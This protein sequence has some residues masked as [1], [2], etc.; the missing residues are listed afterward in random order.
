[1]GRHTDS[2]RT[3][4]NEQ[5]DLNVAI[6]GSLCEIG[7]CHEDHFIVNHYSFGV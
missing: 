2:Y 7:R 1:V 3:V 5:P 4:A 6:E